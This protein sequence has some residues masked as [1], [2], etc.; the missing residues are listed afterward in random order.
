MHYVLNEGLLGYIVLDTDKWLAGF[1][2]Q[3]P[4]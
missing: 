1:S 4:R 3:V 2:T